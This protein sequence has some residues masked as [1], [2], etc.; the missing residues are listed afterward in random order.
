MAKSVYEKLQT[1]FENERLGATVVELL[2]ELGDVREWAEAL[3][4][5]AD[6]IES[7]EAAVQDYIDCEGD[8]D[9]KADAKQTALDSFDEMVESW[10]AAT[11]LPDVDNLLKGL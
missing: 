11:A 10:E 5:L 2:G 9:E 3:T 6:N 7:V 4:E 1:A 8:R